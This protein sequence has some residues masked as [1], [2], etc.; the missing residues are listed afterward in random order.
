MKIK[1]MSRVIRDDCCPFCGNSRA[2]EIYDVKGK[3][4]MY[5]WLLDKIENGG[6]GKI[7]L[8]KLEL[9]GAKCT[10]CNK[11]FKLDWADNTNIPRP[12]FSKAYIDNILDRCFNGGEE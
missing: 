3:P 8:E 12:L 10:I 6:E 2:I 9:W 7:N 1:Y 11:V 5:T 4:L